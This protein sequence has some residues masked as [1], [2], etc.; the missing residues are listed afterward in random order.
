[1]VIDVE[2]VKAALV[3]FN[4]NTCPAGKVSL[5]TIQLSAIFLSLVITILGATP[6]PCPTVAPAKLLPVNV[7]TLNPV[8][9]LALIVEVIVPS[10]LL[11]GEPEPASQHHAT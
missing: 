7:T 10:V 4:T 5:W 8:A 11:T 9:G 2:D 1:M 6:S 3:P